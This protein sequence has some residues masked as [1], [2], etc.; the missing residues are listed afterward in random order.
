ML[1]DKNSARPAELLPLLNV[2][3]VLVENL[4]PVVVAIADEQAPFGI[5]GQAM[6]QVEFARAGSFFPPRLDE[7]SVFRKL[8]DAVVGI[9]AVSIGN[10]NITIRSDGHRGRHIERVGT[11]ARDARLAESH[12]YFSVGT[13]F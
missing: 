12:Q 9:A 4:N 2:V 1:V 8:H 5:E 6:R 7:L 11:I 3:S 10:K 13:A